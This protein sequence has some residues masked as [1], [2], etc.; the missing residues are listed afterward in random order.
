MDQLSKGTSYVEELHM[1]KKYHICCFLQL[2]SAVVDFLPHSSTV[3][4]CLLSSNQSCHVQR[5][6]LELPGVTL[7][8]FP[9]SS[10][11]LYYP[12]FL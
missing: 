5:G 6:N 7:S 3:A 4:S 9:D 1:M 8:F 2:A 11:F 10:S 12:I